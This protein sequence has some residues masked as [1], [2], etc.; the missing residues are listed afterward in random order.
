MK[1]SKLIAGNIR[2]F[3]YDPPTL[4]KWSFLHLKSVAGYYIFMV[5]IL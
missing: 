5:C 1:P 4:A 2:K 3:L